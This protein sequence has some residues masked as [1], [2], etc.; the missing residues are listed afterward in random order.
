MVPVLL[1]LPSNVSEVLLTLCDHWPFMTQLTVAPLL[2]S[3]GDHS[4][5]RVL[6]GH[7]HT[8]SD[9]GYQEILSFWF[10]WIS[11][12]EK[13]KKKTSLGHP[14]SSNHHPVLSSSLLGSS[15]LCAPR[16]GHSIQTHLP[17]LSHSSVAHSSLLISWTQGY[18][19]PLPS[20]I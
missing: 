3:S 17:A 13:K 6:P 5:G 1:L 8:W 11:D 14:T 15:P 20:C 9:C 7:T 10:G 12:F 4:A 2:Q 16:Q 18:D 19:F